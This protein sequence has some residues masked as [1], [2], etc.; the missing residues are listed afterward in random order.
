MREENDSRSQW[1]FV[2]VPPWQSVGQPLEDDTVI[3]VTVTTGTTAQ[4]ANRAGDQRLDA[5][6]HGRKSG[7]AT[8][9]AARNSSEAASAA[10]GNACNISVSLSKTMPEE[11]WR[12]R[13]MHG[14]EGGVA[15]LETR[16]GVCFC[17]AG[18][19]GFIEPASGG[20]R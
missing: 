7:G 16:L 14:G 12:P 20:R 17:A 4:G 11:Y 10:G 1:T 8:D 18:A 19:G 9:A 13:E 6:Q 15:S 5:V 3:T 2:W